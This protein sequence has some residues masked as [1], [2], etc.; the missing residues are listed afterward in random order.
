MIALATL[1]IFIFLLV[2]CCPQCS[3]HSWSFP[4]LSFLSTA[5][6]PFTDGLPSHA[7]SVM[8]VCLCSWIR[9]WVS[10]K[11][12]RVHEMWCLQ[13]WRCEYSLPVFLKAT[14]SCSS[15]CRSCV[16]CWVGTINRRAAW[17]VICYILYKVQK[18]D[19]SWMLNPKV[20][21]VMF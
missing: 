2:L 21:M 9:C 11:W 15:L 5:I 4:L 14:L 3:L 19:G 1:L 16:L 17:T 7:K 13:S 12:R 10:R 18:I 20:L 8:V 6:S